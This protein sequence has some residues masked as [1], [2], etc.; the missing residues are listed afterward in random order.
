MT[1]Q[2]GSHQIITQTGGTLNTATQRMN[3][4]GA[5]NTQTI[6]Q[7]GS[8]GNTATQTLN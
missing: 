1:G 7:N 5:T 4:A 3:V 6:L 2:T 8:T